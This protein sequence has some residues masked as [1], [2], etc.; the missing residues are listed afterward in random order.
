M[1]NQKRKIMR[2]L[3]VIDEEFVIPLGT[4]IHLVRTQEN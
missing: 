3:Y 4:R 2:K 1:K